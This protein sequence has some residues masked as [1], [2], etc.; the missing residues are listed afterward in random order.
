[1]KIGFNAP[2][3]VWL[4]DSLREWALDMTRSEAFRSNPYFDAEAYT[5]LLD[6]HLGGEKLSAPDMWRLWPPLHL[7]FWMEHRKRQAGKL[8][9]KTAWLPV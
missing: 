7:I 2:H 5:T 9:A 6:K 4:K 3:E 8:T 1:M